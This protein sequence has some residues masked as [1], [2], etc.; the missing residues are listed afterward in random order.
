[1]LC[2]RFLFNLNFNQKL[3]INK[4]NFI[5]SY[6]Y[7]II[8]LSRFKLLGILNNISSYLYYKFG[9]IRVHFYKIRNV[10]ILKF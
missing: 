8:I 3:L 1:M 4:N 10:F 7:L 6:F 2:K 5:P 9:I